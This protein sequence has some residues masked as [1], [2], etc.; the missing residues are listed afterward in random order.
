M[1]ESKE[2]TNEGQLLCIDKIGFQTAI[3]S[4]D[5]ETFDGKYKQ[6]LADQD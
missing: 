6:Y 2:S 1:L 3:D 5:N 4:C